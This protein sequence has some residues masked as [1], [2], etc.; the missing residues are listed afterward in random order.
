M[1]F[2]KTQTLAGA[3]IGV[4]SADG[5]VEVSYDVDRLEP[6]FGDDGGALAELG[7]SIRADPASEH[8]FESLDLLKPVDPVAMRDFMIFEE[9]VL[10]AWRMQ[11]LKRG[12]DVWYEQPIG[13]F[14]N[15]ATIRGPRE[16]IEIPGG[17]TNMDFE[18][19]VAAV[20]GRDAV[21]VTPTQAARH[22]AGFVILSDWSARDLQFREM[23]GRLGPFKG[24]DFG[25]SLGPI[26]VTP[27]EIEDRREGTGY[28]LEMTSAVNGR[29]YGVDRWTSAY[30]SMEELISYSSWSSRVEA[31]S[32]IGSGTCQGGCILELSLRSSPEE[33]PWLVAGDE[34]TL[35]IETMGEI[36]AT[37]SASAFGAWPGRRSGYTENEV[38][39]A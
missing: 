21:S 29:R 34:V 32:I 20:I 14:S 35:A 12:P 36:H 10:P 22:L 37:L 3:R 8:D 30:W 13:Y 28:D 5:R 1:R 18:L 15:A 24:K 38:T 39:S 23:D 17:C 16:A 9:H 6:Y 7:E 19:E 31:G 25:S 2:I 26:F 4:I 33:Y 11:G 27:D